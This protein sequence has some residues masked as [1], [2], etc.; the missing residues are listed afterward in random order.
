M[1]SIIGFM[2]L[3][4]F[5]SFGISSVYSQLGGQ[6]I[7]DIIR[8]KGFTE[9]LKRLRRDLGGQEIESKA[10]TGPRRSFGESSRAAGL[11]AEFFNFILSEG[12][13][14]IG[15]DEMEELSK[16]FIMNY[17]SSCQPK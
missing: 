4:I 15:E 7:G 6:D 2:A 16:E 14:M 8:A 17:C 11:E 10:S 9:Y 13:K 5:M 12:S 1:K 3:I